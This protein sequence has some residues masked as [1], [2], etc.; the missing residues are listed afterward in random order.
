MDLNDEITRELERALQAR[1]RGNEGQARVC[2]RRAAG[3]AARDFLARRGSPPRTSSAYDLLKLLAEDIALPAAI[4]ERAAIL[5]LRVDEEF[6]LP[7]GV[8]LIAEAR[9]LC[10]SL[11]ASPPN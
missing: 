3:I 7:P 9:L 8:D 10:E 2:A 5:T 6:K 11:L 4:Q 1:T